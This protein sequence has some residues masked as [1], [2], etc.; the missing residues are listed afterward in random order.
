MIY[1]KYAHFFKWAANNWLEINS[2]IVNQKLVQNWIIKG[3]KGLPNHYP[4][5]FLTNDQVLDMYFKE[6]PHLT[7]KN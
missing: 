3:I 1:Y 5:K 4:D 6:N 7:I 2:T